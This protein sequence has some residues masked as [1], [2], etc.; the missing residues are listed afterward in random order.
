MATTKAEQYGFQKVAGVDASGHAVLRVVQWNLL[1]QN[2]TRTAVFPH[3]VPNNCLKWKNRGPAIVEA[4]RALAADVLL[5][6]EVDQYE[7]Y[8]APIL[9]K[10]GYEACYKQRTGKKQDG[11]LVAWRSDR[12]RCIERSCIEYND[13]C[14]GLT[15]PPEG[16]D[17]RADVGEPDAFTRLNRDCVA[18]TAL[19]EVIPTSDS[20]ISQKILC[21]A[22][23][24]FWDPALAEVKLAQAELL[25]ARLK[26][27]SS[28]EGIPLLLGADMNSLP[29]DPPVNALMA[30]AGLV[31]ALQVATSDDIALRATTVTPKFT[32]C[33]DY[34]MCSPG[35]IPVGYLP[36]PSESHE[37]VGAGLP[38]GNW[39]SDHFPVGVELRLQQQSKAV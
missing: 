7:S 8:Y 21:C 33:I 15:P 35:L 24:L 5:L 30:S 20:D 26:E 10:M 36:L 39:P 14:E 13:L 4:L 28:G 12:V 34:I 11:S 38:N 17:A 2:L 31:N 22:T 16:K 6:E 18:A 3:S 25:A 37:S 32:G 29:R 9:R 23:Q 19:L 27:K 1:A